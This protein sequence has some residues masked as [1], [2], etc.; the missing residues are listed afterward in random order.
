MVIK[1]NL[2]NQITGTYL[3]IMMKDNIN[4]KHKYFTTL[5]L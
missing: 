2:T 3:L 4:I 5:T 1:F